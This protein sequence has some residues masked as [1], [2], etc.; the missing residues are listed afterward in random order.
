[1]NVGY[2]NISTKEQNTARQDA[3]MQELGVE[4]IFVDKYSCKDT[5][6]PE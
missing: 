5:H 4:R 1:M 2:V 3:L 6:R